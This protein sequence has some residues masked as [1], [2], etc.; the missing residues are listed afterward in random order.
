LPYIPN[1]DRNNPLCKLRLLEFVDYFLSFLSVWVAYGAGWADVFVAQTEDYATVGF[2]GSF[3][4]AVDGFCSKGL[5]MAEFHAFTTGCAFSVVDFRVPENFVAWYSL[6]VILWHIRSSV[7]G[8]G[9]VKRLQL[10]DF[11]IGPHWEGVQL[12]LTTIDLNS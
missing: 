8:T 4:I 7:T 3:L 6:V 2:D 5:C 10:I 11:P 9:N 12:I 1:I